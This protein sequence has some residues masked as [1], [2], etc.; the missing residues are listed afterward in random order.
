MWSIMH[1]AC[2]ECFHVT[3]LCVQLSLEE[4]FEVAVPQE[5]ALPVTSSSDELL[6]DISEHVQ[7]LVDFYWYYGFEVCAFWN[8]WLVLID[9]L[10]G[11]LSPKSTPLPFLLTFGSMEC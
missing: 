10:I 4:D 3:W 6:L 2:G 1:D 5:P 11:I 8:H 9:K 7:Q